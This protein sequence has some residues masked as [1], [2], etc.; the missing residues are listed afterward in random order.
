MKVTDM[1]L[2]RTRHAVLAL[3]RNS[4][5]KTKSK[6]TH[7]GSPVQYSRRAHSRILERLTA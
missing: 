2:S 1:T 3:I 7:P 5:E 4:S 6:R